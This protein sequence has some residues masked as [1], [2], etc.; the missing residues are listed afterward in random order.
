MLKSSVCPSKSRESRIFGGIFGGISRGG[1]KSL[2]TKTCVQF[3]SPI[4]GK[5]FHSR[6]GVQTNRLSKEIRDAGGGS[7]S[8]PHSLLSLFSVP[9][10]R[11]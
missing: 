10:R 5:N 4:L 3:S 8:D 11:P 6:P 1:P 2:R 9:C 7:K